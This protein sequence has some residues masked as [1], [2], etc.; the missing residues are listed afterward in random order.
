MTPEQAL[1]IAVARGPDEGE[2]WAPFREKQAQAREVLERLKGEP[3]RE[4]TPQVMARI[5]ST[6]D[7][8]MQRPLAVALARATIELDIDTQFVNRLTRATFSQPYVH[9]LQRLPELGVDVWPLLVELLQHRELRAQ[10]AVSPLT[11]LFDRKPRPPVERFEEV[12]RLN[13]AIALK[14]CFELR[15]WK[16]RSL[17]ELKAPLVRFVVESDDEPLRCEALARLRNE[18]LDDETLESLETLWPRATPQLACSL[19]SVFVAYAVLRNEFP[20]ALLSDPRAD[21]RHA[22]FDS[23]VSR[24]TPRKALPQVIHAWSDGDV[25]IRTTAERVL[26]E[27][28]SEDELRPE[29]LKPLIELA[30]RDEVSVF[31]AWASARHPEVRAW[32]LAHAPAGSA[33]HRSLEASLTLV[34]GSCGELATGQSWSTAWSQPKAFASLVSVAVLEE[35]NWDRL[36]LLRCPACSAH[37]TLAERSEIDVNSRHDEW[38]LRRLRLDDLRREHATRVDLTRAPFTTWH[39]AAKNDLQHVDP[40]VRELAQ[41]ELS[42]PRAD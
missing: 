7:S 18:G 26:R 27:F 2:G 10:D 34:C 30:T 37:F 24:K 14:V 22:A 32:C 33:L 28:T 17:D 15:L 9:A 20:G 19:A 5:E 23:F 38:W 29:E 39:E 6:D 11:E 8:S 21:V 13:P 42:G 35:G 31:L 1:I 25:R 12:L 41:W 4:L 36:S 40:K 3:L 16:S